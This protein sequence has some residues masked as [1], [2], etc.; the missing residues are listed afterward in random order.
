MG[1]GR[2][3]KDPTVSA[4]S[5]RPAQAQL[6]VSSTVLPALGIAGKEE[7]FQSRVRL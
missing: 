6:L 3:A 7:D 1:H 4:T 5:I 2:N